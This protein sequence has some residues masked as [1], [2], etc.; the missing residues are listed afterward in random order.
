MGN[1]KAMGNFAPKMEIDNAIASEFYA[2]ALE[3]SEQASAVAVAPVE[4]HGAIAFQGN[5]ATRGRT[6]AA[7]TAKRP[8]ER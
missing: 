2:E 6:A 7:Q 5:A 3:Y 8:S 1:F 4:R